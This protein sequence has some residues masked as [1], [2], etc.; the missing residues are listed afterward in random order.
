MKFNYNIK[1]KILLKNE[2]V[3]FFRELFFFNFVDFLEIGGFDFLFCFCICVCDIFE[4]LLILFCWVLL[5]I[6][7]WWILDYGG[8]YDI[9]IDGGYLVFVNVFMKVYNLDLVVFEVMWWIVCNVI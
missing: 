7:N 6:V 4:F 2:E 3:R 9:V 8:W 1:I 5:M